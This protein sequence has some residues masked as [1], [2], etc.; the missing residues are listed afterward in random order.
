[1]NVAHTVKT[2]VFHST[3]YEAKMFYKIFMGSLITIFVEGVLLQP[4]KVLQNSH[5]VVQ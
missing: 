1:M 4:I 3:F 2:K 5:K